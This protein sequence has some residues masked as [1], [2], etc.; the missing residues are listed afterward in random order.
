ME[1]EGSL[2]CSSD[3]V[4]GPRPEADE[5]GPHPVLFL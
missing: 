4:A 2:P 1:H 5:S 3:P